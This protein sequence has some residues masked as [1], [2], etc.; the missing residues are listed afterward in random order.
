MFVLVIVAEYISV[1]VVDLHVAC[2]RAE[3]LSHLATRSP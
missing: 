1:Y 3:R 2:R